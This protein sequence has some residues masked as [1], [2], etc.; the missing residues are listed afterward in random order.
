MPEKLD[1]NDAFTYSDCK[2]DKKQYKDTNPNELRQV[3]FYK[4]HNTPMRKENITMRKEARDF[5][6]TIRERSRITWINLEINRMIRHQHRDRKSWVR[7]DKNVMFYIDTPEHGEGP[8]WEDVRIR[9]TFDACTGYM[10]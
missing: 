2:Q 3:S 1:F 8:R 6:N 10:I 7:E 9:Q 4:F 5:R